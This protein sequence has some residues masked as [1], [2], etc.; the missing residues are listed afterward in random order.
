LAITILVIKLTTHLQN[1]YKEIISNRTTTKENKTIIEHP[2][3]QK[4][5]QTHCGK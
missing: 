1:N 3:N 4:I 5:E 2:Q